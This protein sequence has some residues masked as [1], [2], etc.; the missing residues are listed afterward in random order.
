MRKL[1]SILALVLMA[2]AL[3][4]G[5]Q[6]ESIDAVKARAASAEAKDQPRLFLEI[7]Q[8]Q[9][10][11]AD[12]HYSKGETGLGRAA[13][14]DVATYSQRAAAA[15]TSTGKHRKQAEIALRK[16]SRRLDDLRLSLPFEDQAPLKSALERIEQAH[17]ELLTQIFK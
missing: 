6:E 15:A 13:V 7:A 1:G 14:E 12:Q 17:S 4:A 9:L 2:A 5:K 16:I 10:K 8:R 3:C 11:T